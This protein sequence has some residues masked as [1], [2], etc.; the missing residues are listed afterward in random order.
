MAPPPYYDK[1][2]VWNWEP[3]PEPEVIAELEGQKGE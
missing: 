1:P 3:D 2:V